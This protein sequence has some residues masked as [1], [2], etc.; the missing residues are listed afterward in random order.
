MVDKDKGYFIDDVPDDG[1][2]VYYAMM[3]FVDLEYQNV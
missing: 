3:S 2:C 1:T